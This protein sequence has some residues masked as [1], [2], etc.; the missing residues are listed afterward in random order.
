MTDYQIFKA[1]FPQLIIDENSF[2][3]LVYGGDVH[4]LRCEGGFAAV[5]K[6][7]TELL[8]VAPEYRSR[9][10]G[11]E[12]LKQCERHIS[13]EYPKVYL[14]GSILPGAVQGSEGFFRRNGYEIG[15]MFNEMSL[16]LG[17]F[18]VPEYKAPAGAEFRFY[19]GS[20]D[21]MRSAVA[22]VDEEWVQYFGEDGLFFVCLMDGS[23]ASFCIVSEDE[24]CL[25]SDGK[26]VGSIGCVGTVP[27]F[28]RNGIGLHMVALAAEHLK[29]IG[30]ER[31]FIHY[32]HL[33]KWYGKLGAETF[34]R[35]FT[36]QK[37]V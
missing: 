37:A 31:A 12:L 29:G 19:N 22:E 14:S 34:L 30:C 8:C 21:D 20:I 23:I 5:R 28:R 6:D 16:E 15:G 26:R 18:T 25:L 3:R 27:Q 7:H 10:I 32:T 24:C 17:G 9:G 11:T 35:F 2:T 36:A 1:C 13:A 4:I 33:D